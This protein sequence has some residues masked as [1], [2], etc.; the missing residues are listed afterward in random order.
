M[1]PMYSLQDLIR[2]DLCET[3][4]PPKHCELCHTYLCEACVREHLSDESKDHYIVPF[5]LRG[6]IPKCT[7]HSSKKCTKLCKTCNVPVCPLCIVSSEHKKHKTE[8]IGKATAKTKELIRKDLK[9]FD[10]SIY[11]KYQ[12]AAINIPVQR[13]EVYKRSRKLTIALD[14]QG[15]D[16][17]ANIDAIIQGMKS[18][19]DDMDAQ[20]ITAIDRQKDAINHT[21][22]EITQF[23]VTVPTFTPR[24]INKEQIHQQ[25]GPLSKLAITFEVRPL[26]DEPRILTDIQT[27]CIGLLSASCL[28]DVELW[29][30]RSGDKIM[31]LYNLQG[32]LL[33]SIETKSGN[34]PQDLAVTRSGGIL[35]ADYDD[36]S[37]NLI[38]GTHKQTLIQL[39]EWKPL[40]LCSALSGDLLV[41]MINN[42]D[43]QTKVVR[44]SGSTQKQTIQWDDKCKPLYSSTGYYKYLSQNRNLDIC[45]ADRDACAVVVVSAAGKLRFR[46]TGTLYIPRR[47]FCPFGITT[48]SQCN[49]LTYDEYKHRI[50]IIDQDG[51]FLRYIENCSLQGPCGLCV[52]SSDKLFVTEWFTGEVKKIQFYKY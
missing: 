16:L 27:K 46:Y 18:E 17:H 41:I 9:E 8:G 5:K 1:D 4:V 47:S 10:K 23:Q 25:I 19:I 13:A 38:C 6:I 3:P 21:I 37:I 11:P 45:V 50:H 24:E 30:F 35:Y 44:Y 12:E 52:N 2:C 43:K 51:H 33:K 22:T 32:E 36:S 15:E 28:S 48:D 7:K 39:H 40:A 29:T 42:D 34:Y 26:L 49:I 20:H 31:R 14:K